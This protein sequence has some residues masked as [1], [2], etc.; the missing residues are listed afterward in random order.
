VEVVYLGGDCGSRGE[1]QFW[2]GVPREQN[3]GE[4][5]ILIMSL[6]LWQS[7]N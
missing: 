7:Q 3:R 6:S 1:G 2:A 5:Q 4:S